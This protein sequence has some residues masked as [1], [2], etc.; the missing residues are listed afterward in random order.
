MICETEINLLSENLTLLNIKAFFH[1]NAK[2]L[3]Y[4]FHISDVEYPIETLKS[5][6]SGELKLPIIDC[7]DGMFAVIYTSKKHALSRIEDEFKI[8]SS[9]LERFVK[10]TQSMK[11][12]N[13]ILVQGE[14]YWFTIGLEKLLESEQQKA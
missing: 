13:G 6:K 2:E 10:M 8:G 14:N 12:V 9:R 1:R 4:F 7:E 11:S 5:F 3:V